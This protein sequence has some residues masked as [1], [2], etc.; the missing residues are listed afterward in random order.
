MKKNQKKKFL[1]KKTSNHNS[2]YVAHLRQRQ[3][4]THR[5]AITDTVYPPICGLELLRVSLFMF[6]AVR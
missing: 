3:P 5:L 4:I 6:R 2:A 1:I